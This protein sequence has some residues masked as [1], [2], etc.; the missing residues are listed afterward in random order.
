MENFHERYKFFKGIYEEYDCKGLVIAHHLYDSLETYLLQKR[1]RSIVKHYGLD[2]VSFIMGMK[3]IRPLLDSFKDDLITY[4]DSN[5]IL[6]SIDKSNLE[7]KYERNKIRNIELSKMT[8]EEILTLVNKMAKENERNDLFFKS[9][10]NKFY[11]IV[12]NEF[13][14]L[15]KFSAL[16]VDDKVF[17]LY[18]FLENYLGDYLKKLSKNRLK[19]LIKRYTAI[20]K[21]PSLQ[22]KVVKSEL[23]EIAK[24]YSRPRKTKLIKE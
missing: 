2:E 14:D 19:D 13:I 3:V 23:K 7:N 22:L 11:E 20:I 16:S 10:N 21:S 17:I 9:L 24:A 4:C 12:N 1:R 15:N 8:K 5:N 6:Y 18:M